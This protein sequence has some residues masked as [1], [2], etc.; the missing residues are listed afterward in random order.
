[1]I[2]WLG[3]SAPNASKAKTQDSENSFFILWFSSSIFTF[4]LKPLQA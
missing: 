2:Y 1:M 4:H 3:L